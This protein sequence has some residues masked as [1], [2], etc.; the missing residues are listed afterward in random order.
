MFTKILVPVDLG[1]IERLEKALTAAAE[2]ARTHAAHVVYMGVTE[3]TPGAVV[4]T[5]EDYKEKLAAFAAGQAETHGIKAA[6]LPIVSTDPAAE[7]NK[8]ILKAV[9]DTGAD[10]V[11]MASHPPRMLDWIL[12]SHGGHIAEH[13]EVSVFIIR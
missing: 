4:R 8:L 13:A 11:V 5:P 12:P 10:L 1:H 2:Q 3:E 9:Q 6:A 7:I